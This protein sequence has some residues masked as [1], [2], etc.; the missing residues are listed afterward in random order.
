MTTEITKERQDLELRL[1]D[2]ILS[3]HKK[4]PNLATKA[5]EAWGRLKNGEKPSI[6]GLQTRPQGQIKAGDWF[7][8][9]EEVEALSNP[10]PNLFITKIIK[11]TREEA[12]HVGLMET[13]PYIQF[14]GFTEDL[15]FVRTY[16]ITK[17]HFKVSVERSLL[18]LCKESFKLSPD[19]PIQEQIN[20][21]K[22]NSGGDSGPTFTPT[23]VKL[24]SEVLAKFNNARAWSFEKPKDISIEETE[25][26]I[27]ISEYYSLLEGMYRSNRL[28]QPI[29]AALPEG[30]SVTEEEGLAA[31]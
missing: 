2:S 16:Q 13:R 23:W 10:N 25:V 15:E 9:R 7:I 18:P 12:N 27:L 8:R 5:L 24:G 20:A 4:N 28:D 6:F 31:L 3:L 14:Y 21:L 19:L 11:G 17:N 22:G 30:D 26:M 1:E 29:K